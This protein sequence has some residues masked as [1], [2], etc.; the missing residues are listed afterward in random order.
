MEGCESFPK[1]VAVDA[2]QAKKGKPDG[3]NG[4]QGEGNRLRPAGPDKC[5]NNAV[6]SKPIPDDKHEGQVHDLQQMPAAPKQG[7]IICMVDSR[8]AEL[9]IGHEN[10]GQTGK[11]DDSGG[12]QQKCCRLGGIRRSANL[13]QHS[14]HNCQRSE[15]Y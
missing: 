13:D 5:A 1:F 15:A 8:R 6:P 7:L 3:G 4:N 2:E 14:Q 10:A 9:E 12:D 11:K